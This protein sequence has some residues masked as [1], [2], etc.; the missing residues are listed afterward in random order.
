[1][2]LSRWGR[3]MEFLALVSYL[4]AGGLTGLLAGL[5]GLG[6][7]VVLVPLFYLSF[8]HLGIATTFLMHLAVGT[9]LRHS[10]DM[11]SNYATFGPRGQRSSGNSRCCR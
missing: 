4:F 6:G 10:G 8:P 9:S 2:L 7:G 3:I 5:F 1:M 11:I